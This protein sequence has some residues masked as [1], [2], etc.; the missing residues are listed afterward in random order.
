MNPLFPGNAVPVGKPFQALPTEA[1]GPPPAYE[2]SPPPYSDN[3]V[4]LASKPST[5]PTHINQS[6]T[7]PPNHIYNLKEMRDLVSNFQ[8]KDSISEHIGSAAGWAGFL[9][10]VSFLASA[11]IALKV[12]LIVGVA[13]STPVGWAVFGG[14]LLIT[15]MLVYASRK[16][17]DSARNCLEPAREL[18]NKYIDTY[19]SP[20][21]KRLKEVEK[22]AEMKLT[23]NFTA[24][25]GYDETLKLK[26]ELRVAQDALDL[27]IN[28]ETRSMLD[29]AK[30]NKTEI[31]ASPL[32][33]INSIFNI[34]Q[35]E[36]RNREM[37][38]SA[39]SGGGGADAA[40]AFAIF[41][42]FA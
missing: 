13:A 15:L 36:V 12:L 28:E 21:V 38:S 25:T 37:R 39:D 24:I 22:E 8:S 6:F 7:P 19:G 31:T 10:F 40:G 14:L 23:Q 1:L 34:A 2:D 20:D 5:L 35:H 32:Q 42:L 26:K 30:A 17:D 16:V 41:E 4:T 3:R 27:Q 9:T 33:Q 29:E 18:R 11:A